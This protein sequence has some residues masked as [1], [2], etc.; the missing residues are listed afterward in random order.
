MEVQVY[1]HLLNH[2][3]ETHTH[4]RVRAFNAAN[5][6]LVETYWEIGRHIVEFEQGGD[7]KAE[8]GTKLLER[9]PRDL[10]VKFGRGFSLSNIK[11]FRQFYSIY[12][13]VRHLRANYKALKAG[14]IQ[15]VRHLRTN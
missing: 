10:S 8:Y 9:L 2:I 15:K 5:M 14:Q 13:L 6:A 12:P 11:R 7:E 1:N 3:S 4:G